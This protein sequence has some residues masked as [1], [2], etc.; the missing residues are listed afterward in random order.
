M[1]KG[2]RSLVSMISL[3]FFVGSLLT[4]SLPSAFAYSKDLSITTQNI[5]FSSSNFMEGRKIRIY[6]TI[7]NNSTSDLLGTV[8]FYDNGSQ[9]NGD[10]A[11]SLFGSRT[12]D[13]F[14]DWY[15]GWGS[16]NIKVQLFPWEAEEDNP[17]NNVI[18]KET[19]VL[20]DTDYDGIPN[21]EDEDDDND[22]V[23]DE[24][25][26]YPL[27]R[28]E[29]ADTDGDGVGDNADEDADNDGVPDE[30][31]DLPLDPT[32][33]TDTDGDGIGDIADEDDDGDGVSDVTEM[34]QGTSGVN[35]DSDGDGTNDGDDPFPTDD[36]EW[37]DNDTDGIGNNA[38]IDDDND[39]ILD[40]SDEFP[41]NK[42]PVIEINEDA[43]TAGLGQE[44]IF[45]S[46]E[47]YDDDGNII[48]YTWT[49][50]DK[51]LK[52]GPVIS[53]EFDELGDHKVTLTI[54]DDGGESRMAEFTVSVLNVRLYSQIFTIIVTLI[55][56]GILIHKYIA[57]GSLM[58]LKN[59]AAIKRSSK[60][61]SPKPTKK[62][63]S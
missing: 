13:V 53:H 48:N 23:P 51:Y 59:V 57:E 40:D 50:D 27:D 60:K 28:D 19:Y 34:N 54:K 1:K 24:E 36:T 55:L 22:G 7:T 5:Q 39:G 61:S 2:T 9:I 21:D 14:V 47:S 32:E 20:Q 33:T 35:P 42:G 38:D 52:E 17:S 11:I 8:R 25:D 63:K 29:S 3:A 45:D 41:L 10:Q 31:D 26:K 46:S 49:I 12:D 56:A 30:E 43:Y 16:H 4:F 15:P 37:S 18:T 6:A 58:T 62:N 44:T